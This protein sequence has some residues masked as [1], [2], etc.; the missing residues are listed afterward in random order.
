MTGSGSTKPFWLELHEICAAQQDPAKIWNGYLGHQWP[1]LKRISVPLLHA[2]PEGRRYIPFDFP[3]TPPGIVLSEIEHMA[4]LCGGPP[5]LPDLEESRPTFMDFSGHPFECEVGFA[6]FLLVGANFSNA[7]FRRR[8]DFRH[9]TFGRWTSFGGAKFCGGTAYQKSTFHDGVDFVASEFGKEADFRGAEFG[10][11]T[12]FRKANFHRAASFRDAKFG[13]QVNFEGASFDARVD[14]VDTEFG[15]WLCLQGTSF[16]KAIDFR[17]AKFGKAADFRDTEFGDWADFSNAEFGD[18]AGFRN[19]RCRDNTYFTNASFGGRVDFATA[20]FGKD[21]DFSGAKFG[22]RTKFN[23]ATFHMPP[24]CFNAEL[25]EDTDFSGIEWKTV[26]AGYMRSLR[27]RRWQARPQLKEARANAS[28]AKRAW[29]RLELLMSQMGRAGDRH[30][31]FKLRM[32]AERAASGINLEWIANCCFDLMAGYGW[33]VRRS[34]LCWLGHVFLAGL[35]IFVGYRDMQT[36]GSDLV[37]LFDSMLVSLA[38]AHAFLGLTG[39]EGYLGGSKECLVPEVA[40]T[41]I[42]NALGTFQAF[43]GPVLLFLVLLALRNRFRLG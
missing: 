8:V 41:E 29:E 36:C 5:T 43:A 23:E 40:E 11:S 18:R 13:D 6:N 37:A 34:F 33:S 35:V 24:K 38:N 28:D 42:F 25:H 32:R 4:K 30:V 21:A 16:R 12:V 3:E 15:D 9:A 22:G 39:D 10:Y 7:E 20:E 19:V 1:Q 26:E 2:S 27:T 31:F 17:G 14:F